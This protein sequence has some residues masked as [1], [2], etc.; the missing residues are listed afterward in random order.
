MQ[1]VQA[2]PVESTLVSESP[3]WTNFDRAEKIIEQLVSFTSAHKNVH[4]GFKDE[5]PK[6]LKFLQAF[7][8]SSTGWREKLETRKT[9]AVVIDRPSTEGASLVSIMK[10]MSSGVDL[11]AL[12]VKVLTTKTTKAGGVLLEVD[13]EGGDV[14]PLVKAILAM[15]GDKARVRRLERRTP[16]LLLDVPEW[17]EEEEIKSGLIR[18]GVPPEALTHNEKSFIVTS[19]NRGRRQ[20]RV[21][22]IDVPYSTAIILAES[23]Y[24][25]LGWTRCRI[26]LLKKLQSTCYRCQEKGH[27][28]VECKGPA[29][30]RRCYR[31]KTEGHF[32]RDCLSLEKGPV[33]EKRE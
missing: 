14:D 3:H 4:R 24:L 15:V 33:Q 26:R 29:K 17:V 13:A 2:V 10:K 1:I 28:A 21:V 30:P 9:V 27:I 8:T 20:D 22:R 25:V 12:G 11:E 32:A 18:A 31:C 19:T 16:V 23:R 6:A 7:R 5:L